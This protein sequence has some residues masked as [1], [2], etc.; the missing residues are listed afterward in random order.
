MAFR[1]VSFDKLKKRIR[2]ISGYSSVKDDDLQALIDGSVHF[3][4]EEIKYWPRYLR[5]QPRTL[6]RGYVDFSEDSFVVYGAG[7]SS[8]NGLYVRNG[9]SADG[10]PA[11]SKYDSDGTTVTGTIQSFGGF[12]WSITNS[13][14]DAI[15]QSFYTRIS[16]DPTPPTSGW[17]SVGDGEDPAPLLEETKQIGQVIKVWGGEVFTNGRSGM[18]DFYTDANGIRVPRGCSDVVWVAYKE[19]LTDEF[20]DG[21]EGTVSEIP[22]EFS[23]YAVYDAAYQ[24]Q[25]AARQGNNNQYPFAYRKVTDVLDQQKLQVTEETGHRIIADRF[26]TMYGVDLSVRP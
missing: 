17:F 12:Q 5:L 24:L 6:K 1:T 8:V 15:D 11:Y 25:F 22:Y 4:Y 7:T 26:K 13:N 23:E 18:L 19:E 3:A 14:V 16:T 10:K 21:T 2:A 20:G 9:T